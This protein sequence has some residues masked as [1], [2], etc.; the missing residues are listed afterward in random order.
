MNTSDFSGYIEEYGKAVYSFCIYLTRNREDADDLYQQTFLTA[1]EKN[2]I[3]EDNNPRS[4][5]ISIA[6]N[7]WKNRQRKEMWRRQKA[8]IVYFDDEDNN[9]EPVDG[10]GSAEDLA[11]KSEE[12]SALRRYV[13]KLPYKLKVV[14]LMFYMEDM[15]MAEIAGALKIPVGTVKSRLNKAKKQLKEW[16]ADYE[17]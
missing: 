17:R 5:L 12:I 9:D 13:L 8:E 15:S 11:V 16:M 1:I 10:R 6:A 4:Y 3:D 2:E 14:V 7:I